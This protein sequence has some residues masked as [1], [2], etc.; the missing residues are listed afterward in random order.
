MKKVII[1]GAG[2]AGLTAA[3]E[4][5]KSK[6]FSCVLIEKSKYVGGM[7][8]SVELLGQTVDIGPHRFFSNDTRV[9]KLWLEVVGKNYQMVD[10]LTRIFYKG[11]YFDYP[12]K[13]INA[14][15]NLGIKETIFCLLSFF[16]VKLFPHKRPDTFEGWVTNRF[17]A[18]LYS[19]FFKSYTEK[20][21]GIPC[22]N[23][24]SE[25]AKQRIKN[26][27][28][29]EAI[30]AAFNLGKK[31]HKTLV[32]QFA[33]PL[34]GNGF[35]YEKM[36]ELYLE[37]GGII[38]F[39]K[40][41]KEIY[42][43]GLHYSINFDDVILKSEFLISSMPITSFLQIFKNSPESII[44]QSANL[45]FR[46]TLLI[47]V[48]LENVITFKD[49]WLYIQDENI[50][51]G[52]VT[53]F[54]NWVK[55]IKNNNGRTVLA[56]E[57][58]CYDKDYIWNCEETE[59]KKIVQNDLINGNFIKSLN[60]IVD[61]A[62]IKVPMCYPVYD[63]D[64]KDSLDNVIIYTKEFKNLHLIGRY[65]AFKYNNQDHSILMGLLTAKNIAGK[66]ENDLWSINT[67][68]EYHESSTITA[69]GLVNN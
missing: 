29:G 53:N 9:N 10:R 55:T 56:F 45:K 67:D 66:E 23:L 27:S 25:F 17:G 31:K 54:N 14:F 32:D 69:T 50:L 5:S 63:K 48:S 33:Y 46:N 8:R 21:W 65:G 1:I 40:S 61:Y 47:Y 49:Q 16:L 43:D 4:I 7:A 20:L 41:I 11:K 15:L 42:F 22:E 52:R 28:L 38:Y 60:N 19:I 58:W 59:L 44:N 64:Y 37:N 36:K 12:L 30:I 51:S 2:P 24:T 18:R 13:P 68:Y 26:F 39:D 3:Y 34:F 57:Y 35:V 6:E 62:F